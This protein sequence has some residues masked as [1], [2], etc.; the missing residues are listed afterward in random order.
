M[1]LKKKINIAVQ[2]TVFTVSADVLKVKLWNYN[3]AFQYFLT[4][5]Q[6][7]TVTIRNRGIFVSNNCT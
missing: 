4:M 3:L 2:L 1:N 5:L 6:G 7:N